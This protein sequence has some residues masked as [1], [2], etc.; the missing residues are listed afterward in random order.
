MLC[1]TAAIVGFCS[2]VRSFV[3]SRVFVLCLFLT[4]CVNVC[5]DISSALFEIEL[6]ELTNKKSNSN[7]NNEKRWRRWDD[8]PNRSILHVVCMKET[9]RY[10]IGSPS[11]MNDR[12][13]R[14]TYVMAIHCMGSHL[15]QHLQFM[16]NVRS[17]L[18]SLNHL[19]E[20]IERLRYTDHSVGHANVCLTIAAITDVVD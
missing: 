13:K 5:G 8:D 20:S 9:V 2:F 18:C 19:H 3:C 14:C 15:E 16:L 11:Y 1:A 4:L 17:I 6:S 10:T 12:I 7:S